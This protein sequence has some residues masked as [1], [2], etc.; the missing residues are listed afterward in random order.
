MKITS[1]SIIGLLVAMGMVFASIGSADAQTAADADFNGNGEVDFQ[2]FLLFV[3]KFNTSEGDSG[4][5][6]KYDIDGSGDV[7][8]AD[9]LSFVRFFGETVPAP[10]L[11]LTGVAPAEG[12][13]GTLIELVGQ[14]DANAAYQVKFDTVLLPVFAQNAERITTM[15]P[16]LPGGSVP[17]RVVDAS[18]RESEPVSFRVLAL[19]EPRMNAEQLQQTVAGIGDG[20]GN[21]LAPLTAP[22]GIFSAADAAFLKSEMDKLNAAWGVLGERIAALPPEDAALLVHLLDNSGALG[23]LEGLGRID[24]SASK[25]VGLGIAFG[26]QNLFKADVMSFLMGNASA[27]TSLAT[28]IAVVVPGGQA[29]VPILSAIDAISGATKSVIDAIFPT[30]LENLRVEISPTPVAVDGT[31]EVAY[32]GDFVTESDAISAVGGELLE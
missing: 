13:P 28:V 30:D 10:A 15:M 32:F 8:F 9:F 11:A 12:M 3:S 19:P 20:I 6:A 5:E 22:D 18:G 21:V 31:S 26:H 27:A 4:Y 7:G 24:L 14:F 16:V 2:D 25:A 29:L 17:V 23:I 1:R